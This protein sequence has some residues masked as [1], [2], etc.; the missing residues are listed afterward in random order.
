[1]RN[2]PGKKATIIN[3]ITGKNI[4]V[5]VMVDSY[6]GF[7]LEGDEFDI[8]GTTSVLPITDHY[9]FVTRKGGLDTPL[10]ETSKAIGPDSWLLPDE[11]P[12]DGVV[13]SE[14]KELVRHD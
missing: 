8:G 4:G 9:F 2:K 10:G 13:T 6:Q 11:E 3:S 12:D 14:T 1:M 7:F 5:Q